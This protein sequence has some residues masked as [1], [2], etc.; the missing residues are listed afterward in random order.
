MRKY[1]SLYSLL[2]IFEAPTSLFNKD[3]KVNAREEASLEAFKNFDHLT[4]RYDT[5]ATV[6][7]RILFNVMKEDEETVRAL[8]AVKGEDGRWVVPDNLSP[9]IFADVWGK[10][11]PKDLVDTAPRMT[12]T[13][14]GKVIEGYKLIEDE[15]K[16]GDSTA[17]PIMYGAM[18]LITALIY[19]GAP[20]FLGLLAIPY[21]W[22]IAQSEGIKEVVRSVLITMVMPL[23]MG[24]AIDPSHGSQYTQLVNGVSRSGMSGMAGM[25][26]AAVM[27][28]LMLTLVL[29]GTTT[30]G[31]WEK[32]KKGFFLSSG[33][34][35]LLMGVFV[36]THMFPSL[37]RFLP[38]V[39]FLLPAMYPM[40]YSEREYI[41]RSER[42]V[43]Q[44]K[45]FN[46]ATQGQ[47]ANAHIDA[48]RRQAENAAKDDTPFI[49][50]GKATGVMTDKEYG[51]APD[52]DTWVGLTALDLTMHYLVFGAT[53]KGK[54]ASKL[55]PLA[56]ALYKA[57]INGF[58]IGIFIDCGKGALPGDLSGIID[59]QV[60]SGVPFAYYQ[61]LDADGAKLAL[62]TKTMK[63]ARDEGKDAI[64]VNG[65]KMLMDHIL[66]IQWA[67][68]HHEME[69]KK[70]AAE[71]MHHYF[72]LSLMAETQLMSAKTEG[73]KAIL[74]QQITKIQNIYNEWKEVAEGDR[75]WLWN[76]EC[77]ERLRQ[78]I[79]MPRKDKDGLWTAGAKM[80]ELLHYLGYNASEK[81]LRTEPRSIYSVVGKGSILDDSFDYAMKS[82]PATH[83]EARS[84]FQMNAKDILHPLMRGSKLIDANGTRWCKLEEGVQP[85]MCLYGKVTAVFLPEIE[86]GDTGL[87]VSALVKQ[88][89]YKGIRRR[90]G[91]SEAE[92]RAEGQTPLALLWDE[93]QS[94]V[95]EDDIK[96]LPQAR[97]AWVMAC[98]ATQGFDSLIDAFGNVNAAELFCNTFQSVDC[99][100]T[101]QATYDY[102]T[103]RFGTALMTVFVEDTRGIDYDGSVSKYLG[104][105]F[106]DRNHP[107]QAAIQKI[108]K[109]GGARF[110]LPIQRIQSQMSGFFNPWMDKE[111]RMNEQEVAVGFTANV[112]GQKEIQPLFKPEEFSAR[113]QGQGVSIAFLQR[114]G[115]PRVD[116][117]E[118]G[119]MGADELRSTKQQSQQQGEAA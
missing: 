68:V 91:Q 101:S 63:K 1:L 118:F 51:F 93:V 65:A 53:G 44:G 48:R 60:K 34:F 16:G 23:V 61:G 70:L 96:L 21:I 99:L 8:G 57:G 107:N 31:G 20:I 94:L 85:E 18:V 19:L 29:A 12:R 37:A 97:S 17:L 27:A 88:R 64:W 24:M 43:T 50:L 52:R 104:S 42:L 73:E 28:I 55:R 114:A 58:K 47:L 14:D 87:L 33:F 119:Y 30:G 3:K 95:S 83:E 79:D 4:G 41:A 86:F 26:I 102:L 59:I 49:P 36:V 100:Q 46:L 56:A 111:A 32:F 82:W 89:I 62:N 80:T 40:F 15:M 98:F 92:W 76:V 10:P 84:S 35:A 5:V 39:I 6:P 109:H 13:K 103:K 74:Q 54:T 110:H 105:P 90:L 22:A 81:R 116:V 9:E 113:L 72:K 117:I 106:N 11:V 69:Q 67:L 77:T 2:S 115:A 108:E 71:K 66:E 38:L 25:A 7:S 45:I 75:Q 78:Y 112:G